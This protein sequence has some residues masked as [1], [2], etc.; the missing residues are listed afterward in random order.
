MS[1]IRNLS[2]NGTN[3]PQVIVHSAVGLPSSSPDLS[4][5]VVPVKGRQR[6]SGIALS[7]ASIPNVFPN[8]HTKFHGARVIRITVVTTTTVGFYTFSIPNGYYTPD[9]LASYITTQLNAIAALFSPVLGVFSVV[10]DIIQRK[11][12][13]N[14]TTTRVNITR[15]DLAA[16]IDSSYVSTLP[17]P[18]PIDIRLKRFMILIGLKN[19]EFTI[20]IAPNTSTYTTFPNPYD[21]CPVREIIVRFGDGSDTSVESLDTPASGQFKIKVNAPYGGIIE[22]ESRVGVQN[23][24]SEPQYFYIDRTRIDIMDCYGN[25]LPNCGGDN[26]LVFCIREENVRLS[27]RRDY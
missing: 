23:A 27:R 2:L 15:I 24:L 17:I 26:V 22:Y 21:M 25:V 14:F 10:H 8:V 3:D 5:F 7:S 11:L 12:S 16:V 13:V 1:D 6:V 20:P 4:W 9:T 18:E 19:G